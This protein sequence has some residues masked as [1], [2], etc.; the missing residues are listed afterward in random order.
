MCLNSLVK[1]PAK[2]KKNLGYSLPL[3]VLAPARFYV[4][5][6]VGQKTNEGGKAEIPAPRIERMSEPR[7]RR[8]E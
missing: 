4:P 3:L 7:R 1:S 8:G 2:A 5:D 6:F